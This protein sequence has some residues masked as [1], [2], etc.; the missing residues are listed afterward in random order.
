[1]SHSTFVRGPLCLIQELVVKY[2]MNCPRCNGPTELVMLFK[3]D[4]ELR[5]CSR[6]NELWIVQ[7][8]TGSVVKIR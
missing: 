8:R 2:A 3:N 4:V 1:M 6:C 7:S 5:G